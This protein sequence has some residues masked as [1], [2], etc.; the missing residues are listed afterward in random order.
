MPE[1]ELVREI[2]QQTLKVSTL[3]GASD[4]WL[5]DRSQR[6]V[7]NVE[8]ICKL[9]DIA[10]ANLAI[11]RFCLACAAY[12]S[13]SGFIHYADS[14]D[15]TARVALADLNVTDLRDFSTQVVTDKLTG[16]LAK[17]K[18]AKINKIII[19]SS[20]KLTEMPEASILSD[21]RSLD[22][23]GAVGIFNEFRRYVVQGK[24]VT[25]A[26]NNWQ[27]KIDY[28]YWEARLRE[29][30]RFESVRRIADRRFHAAEYFMKQLNIENIAKD[31][32]EVMLEPLEK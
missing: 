29:S 23:M 22:D 19:E 31:L 11:D 12:F 32:E 17:E 2:A 6:V 10:E 16:K 5:W 7:R 18:I 30:F 28:R 4:N 27:R 3:T 15:V 14:E 20:N 25:D 8:H 1:I 13:D 24:G 26:I 9:P 21:G